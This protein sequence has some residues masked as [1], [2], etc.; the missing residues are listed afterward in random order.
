MYKYKRS[1]W[2]KIRDWWGLWPV[3]VVIGYWGAAG[4]IVYLTIHWLLRVLAAN[5]VKGL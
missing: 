2:S 5:G 1:L 3:L 4:V